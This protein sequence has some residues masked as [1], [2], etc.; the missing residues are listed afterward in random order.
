MTKERYERLA[1]VLQRSSIRKHQKKLGLIEELLVEGPSKRDPA[2]MNG[3][4][5]ENQLVHFESEPIKPGT[6]VSV[7]IVEAT[8]RFLRG[9]LLEVTRRAKHV[10]RLSV[11]AAS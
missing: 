8:T 5:R 4:T 11:T 6:F 10:T 7:R 9:E 3:R 2:V 1:V